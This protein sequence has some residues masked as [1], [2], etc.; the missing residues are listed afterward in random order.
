MRAK[1]GLNKYDDGGINL[2]GALIYRFN[3]IKILMAIGE[4][5]RAIKEILILKKN[6]KSGLFSG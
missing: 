3:L 6:Y 4:C 2:M 5:S 1:E